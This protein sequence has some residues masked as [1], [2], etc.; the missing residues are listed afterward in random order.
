MNICYRESVFS[1]SIKFV[2][3]CVSFSLGLNFILVLMGITTLSANICNIYLNPKIGFPFNDWPTSNQ[4]RRFD[5]DL[6]DTLEKN[7][8]ASVISLYHAFRD[9]YHERYNLH[10]EE[11]V[12]RYPVLNSDYI[13]LKKALADFYKIEQKVLVQVRKK[14]LMFPSKKRIQYLRRQS[15]KKLKELDLLMDALMGLDTEKIANQILTRLGDGKNINP[16]LQK[17]NYGNEEIWFDRDGEQQ[18]SWSQLIELVELMDLEEGQ[19][20]SDLGSGIGRL[21]LLLGLLRPDIKFVGF[22]LVDIRV[23]WANSAARSNGFRNVSFQ[24]EN[25]ANASLK[26]PLA[27]HFYLFNPTSPKTSERLASALDKLSQEQ[28]FKV[29]IR[30]DFLSLSFRNHFRQLSQPVSGFYMYHSN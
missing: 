11:L 13:Q 21:G 6:D 29:Y 20:V 5:E 4:Y 16:D 28:S 17:Q 30:G 15:M 22:E 2:L 24:T 3:K 8:V 26:L 27:D 12:R 1:K 14:L 10:L 19:M 18:T 7:S 25:L 23:Q 9:G